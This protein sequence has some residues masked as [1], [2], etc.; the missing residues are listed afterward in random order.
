MLTFLHKAMAVSQDKKLNTEISIYT[1]PNRKIKVKLI[2]CLI[3]KIICSEIAEGQN[4]RGNK[5]INLQTD[6]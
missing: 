5:A 1:K 2:C 6:H 4:M 3:Q